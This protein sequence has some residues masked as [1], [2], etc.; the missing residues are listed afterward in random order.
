M[1]SVS[2]SSVVPTFTLDWVKTESGVKTP[3]SRP[4]WMGRD[5]VVSAAR[6]VMSELRSIGGNWTFRLLDAEGAEV[7]LEAEPREWR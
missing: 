2:G 7:P 5:Q 4:F 3:G 1:S 6:N